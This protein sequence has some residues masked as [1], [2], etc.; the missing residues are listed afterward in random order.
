MSVHIRTFVWLT[1]MI[2]TKDVDNQNPEISSNW[3][4]NR[5]FKRCPLLHES[6][7]PFQ[8]ASD[9]LVLWLRLFSAP[10]G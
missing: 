5:K 9:N 4:E 10:I 7:Y 3:P 6:A 2:M 1:G 8:T